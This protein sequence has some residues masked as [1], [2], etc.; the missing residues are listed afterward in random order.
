MVKKRL[1]I[2]NAFLLKGKKKIKQNGV[3]YNKIS[4]M[5]LIPKNKSNKIIRKKLYQ[6]GGTMLGNP[7]IQNPRESGSQRG[8]YEI[9]KLRRCWREGLPNCPG[10]GTE[11][12]GLREGGREARQPRYRF[13]RK[14]H[15]LRQHLRTGRRPQ[16]QRHLRGGT[17]TRPQEP[18][19]RSGRYHQGPQPRG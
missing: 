19:R 15:R 5:F 17:G 1:N 6:S 9:R 3:C 18:P 2:Y 13:R 4:E 12:P 11:R 16:G 14:S 8:E 10:N 7:L